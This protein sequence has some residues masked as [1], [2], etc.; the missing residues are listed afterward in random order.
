MD[1]Q[2]VMERVRALTEEVGRYLYEERARIRLGDIEVKGHGDFVSRADR[3]AER[4]LREGLES[5]LPDSIVMG[6]EESPTARGGKWR[7][8]VDPLDGTANYL[9]GLPVW[10]VS[11]ALED[12][13]ENPEGF[14]PRQLGIVHMPPMNLTWHAVRNGGAF[15]NGRPVQVQKN[16]PVE[17]TALATG[18]P[19]RNRENLDEYLDLFSRL[20]R[21]VGDM[22]RIGTAAADLAWVADGTFGG[23]FEMDLKPWDLA[24]GCLIIDEAGGVATDWWGQDPLSTGWIV[25][26]SEEVYRMQRNAIDGLGFEPPEH[27]WS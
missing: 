25:C 24:A 10:A 13:R 18:F 16:L 27:R 8:I 4:K 11:I 12:R 3:N 22:R 23:Y 9:M 17:R 1:I 7:W 14:G 20:Y 15:R 26:G 6:E 2:K 5:I 21:K 19:F